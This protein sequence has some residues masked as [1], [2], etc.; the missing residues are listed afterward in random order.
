[1]MKAEW[2]L[3]FNKNWEK[4][5]RLKFESKFEIFAESGFLEDEHNPPKPR[6]LST[7]RECNPQHG[8]MSKRLALSIFKILGYWALIWFF[9]I[10]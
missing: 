5:K 1:M 9:Y 4:Y 10:F 3:D 7:K 8:R 2:S 6:P